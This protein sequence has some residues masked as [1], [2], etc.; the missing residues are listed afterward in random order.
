MSE[1]ISRIANPVKAPKKQGRPSISPSS[2]EAM[3]EVFQESGVEA[4]KVSNPEF[5]TCP[6]CA[7]D[8]KFKAKKCRY[9]QHML[10]G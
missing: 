3:W 5:K 6:M 2:E 1:P 10:D 8:I 4:G 7:E 9:C